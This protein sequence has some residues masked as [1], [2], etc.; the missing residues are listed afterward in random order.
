MHDEEW[1]ATIQKVYG[2]SLQEM[3]NEELIEN[4]GR[5]FPID[6]YYDHALEIFFWDE[7]ERRGLE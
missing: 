3:T 5:L 4:H 7:L 2:K 6:N 1:Y